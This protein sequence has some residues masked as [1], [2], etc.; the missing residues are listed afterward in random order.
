MAG[1]CADDRCHSR[2]VC[3]GLTAN[4]PSE[5]RIVALGRD[6]QSSGDDDLPRVWKTDANPHK[7]LHK[8]AV[9]GLFRLSQ[10]L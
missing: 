3:S 9:L 7:P 5:L 1:R 4:N 2:R 6:Q 10:I 8:R